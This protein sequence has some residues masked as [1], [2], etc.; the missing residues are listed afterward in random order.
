MT[1]SAL[2]IKFTLLHR[3]ILL[4][5]PLSSAC[6]V[7]SLQSEVGTMAEQIV[8]HLSILIQISLVQLA[9]QSRAAWCPKMPFPSWRIQL[10]KKRCMHIRTH[11]P[12]NNLVFDVTYNRTI[13]YNCDNY[14]TSYFTISSYPKSCFPSVLFSIFF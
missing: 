7:P 13:A 4:T 12:D 5:Y 14:L 10:E 11:R 8:R 1:G 3:R 9:S 6:P 2:R